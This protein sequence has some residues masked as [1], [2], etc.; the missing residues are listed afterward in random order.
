MRSVDF[1]R[2]WSNPPHKLGWGELLGF[3]PCGTHQFDNIWFC[4]FGMHLACMTLGISKTCFGV[5]DSWHIQD[6]FW[7]A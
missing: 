1:W 7:R 2:E 5:H 4:Y 3:P 6:L